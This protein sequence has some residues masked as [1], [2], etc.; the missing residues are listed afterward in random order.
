MAAYVDWV[1]GVLIHVGNCPRP[2]VLHAI[3][4]AV[5]EF[6][7][8]SRVW[9]FEPVGIELMVDQNRYEIED[10]PTESTICHLWDAYTERRDCD[11]NI[12]YESPNILV[13]KPKKNGQFIPY[14]V[15]PLLSLK[16]RQNSLECPDFIYDDYFEVIQ[17]G[18]VAYLQLQPE[19]PWSQFNMAQ[20]HQLEYERGIDRA[21][22]KINEGLNRPKPS[23]RVKA[24]FL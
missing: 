5:I 1:D 16:P 14:K 23:Y 17:N 8:R 15:A 18:A 21:T 6:C 7:D 22:Q 13:V 11:V 24:N 10:Q 2:A 4:Q 3:K 20:F 12:H 9:L 19:R